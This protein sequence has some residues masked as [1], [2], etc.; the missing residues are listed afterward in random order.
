MAEI[1]DVDYLVIGT[2]AMGMA[3]ADTLVSD[4][5]KTIAM[6]D[7]YARPGGHWTIAYPHVRLHQPSIGYGVN[8]RGFDGEN[9]LDTHGWNKGLLELA[10]GPEVCGYFI[11]VMHQ[12][13]I[14]SG[15]V[16]YYPKHEYTG[17]GNFKSLMTGKTYRV[18]EKTKIVDATY[19]KTEVP[20]MRPPPYESTPDVKVITPNQLSALARPYNHYTIVGVGKTGLD[21]CLWLIGSGVSPSKLTLVVPRDAWYIDRYKFQPGEHFRI[22]NARNFTVSNACVMDATSPED[23]FHR[24]E[25]TGQLMRLSPDHEPTFYRCATVTELEL[26]A[27]REIGT[28]IRKGRIRRITPGT[29]Y[30][31]RGTYTPEPDNLYIDCSAN[32]VPKRPPVPVF[33]DKRITLQPVRYCQQVF[34]AAFIAHIEA[35]Y[36]V[37]DEKLKNTL[38]SPVPHPEFATDWLRLNLQTYRNAL[39][40]SQYPKTQAWLAAARLDWLTEIL[41][42]VPE[43]ASEEEKGAFMQKL[44]AELMALVAKLEAL[45]KML[46]KDDGALEDV[47]LNAML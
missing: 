29:V 3:F 23:L 15:R 39:I 44:G 40:W 27:I 26:S 10:S 41:P 47:Q 25:A 13:L 42:K 34:S 12:T 32:S 19:H 17:D 16:K 8:S 11:A 6:V 24:L 21:A 31:E 33:D 9:K 46:P 5:Q 37:D 20:A 38:T 43:G 45:M 36:P 30:C 28:F 2:G 4:S 7:R 18:S 1:V 22:A 35:A 14:P